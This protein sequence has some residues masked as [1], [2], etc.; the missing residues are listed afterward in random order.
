MGFFSIWFS[1]GLCKH[2]RLLCPIRALRDRHRRPKKDKAPNPK[3]QGDT[4]HS[5]QPDTATSHSLAELAPCSPAATQSSGGSAPRSQSQRGR[6]KA[7]TPQLTALPGCD[8]AGASPWLCSAHSPPLSCSAPWE[9]LSGRQP[10]CFDL[11]RLAGLI[12]ELC[13]AGRAENYDIA[14]RFG[15]ERPKPTQS[16]KQL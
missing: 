16:P 5:S 9:E 10:P 12:G 13:G 2:T 4:G 11:L 7:R 1:S 6:T 8:T 14:E 15:P 3:M